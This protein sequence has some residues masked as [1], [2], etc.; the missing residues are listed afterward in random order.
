M[1]ASADKEKWYVFNNPAVE[2]LNFQLFAHLSARFE[3]VKTMGVEEPNEK[4]VI[5]VKKKT[6]KTEFLFR[7]SDD[8]VLVAIPAENADDQKAL[9]KAL[10]I[11]GISTDP[12]SMSEGDF[13]A[14]R[15]SKIGFEDIAKSVNNAINDGLRMSILQSEISMGRLEGELKRKYGEDW[16]G[17]VYDQTFGN[18]N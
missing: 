1:E 10:E 18:K 13:T 9:I 15:L 17:V 14:I 11:K 5:K 6:G 3:K 7:I 2:A 8:F 4:G 16:L 12:F